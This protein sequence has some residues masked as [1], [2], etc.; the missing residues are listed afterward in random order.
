LPA[1]CSCQ[2]LQPPSTL[3]VPSPS[4]TACAHPEPVR[5]WTPER[6]R[7][8]LVN[9]VALAPGLVRMRSYRGARLLRA[10]R[11]PCGLHAV[12]HTVR[13]RWHKKIA[14]SM[15]TFRCRCSRRY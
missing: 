3:R 13:P 6:R 14:A 7:Y 10:E 9:V 5:S 1:R 8:N 11:M 4:G 15:F 2:V 12:A